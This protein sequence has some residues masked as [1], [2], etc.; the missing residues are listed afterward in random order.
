MV[1]YHVLRLTLLKSGVDP[2]AQ[3][4]Q[5][6]HRFTYSLLPHPGDWREAQTVRHA[7][8]LNAPVICLP[9]VTQAI[10]S[11]TSVLSPFIQTDCSHVIVE[12]VKP[13]EDGNGLIVRLY[14]F[15]NQRGNG[16]LSFATPLY[17]V[18][19]C[20]LLEQPL[21]DVL[22]QENSF[23]FDVKPFEIKTFRVI[24]IEVPEKKGC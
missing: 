4:D 16:T 22:V 2:D 15:H 20:N 23:S 3:A 12:T 17:S 5:G 24:P 14:E 11:S 6:I 8:E 13:A 9:G 10:S 19:A 7:Y 18:Q 1:C 21:A